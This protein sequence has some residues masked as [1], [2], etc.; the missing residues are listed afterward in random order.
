LL[1]TLLFV[2]NSEALTIAIESKK[3]LTRAVLESRILELHRKLDDAVL[4]HAFSE[5]GTLQ[6]ELDDLIAKRVELPTIQELQEL[7]QSLEVEI[8]LAAKI[9]D[10]PGA[11]LGQARLEET[12]NRL[13][14]LMSEDGEANFIGDNI[15]GVGSRA[16]LES[17]IFELSKQVKAALASKNYM[18]ASSFQQLLDERESLRSYF[19]SIAE[20]E[21][22]IIIAKQDLESSIAK[23]D[24]AQAGRVQDSVSEL[25]KILEAERLA[26]SHYAI[27]KDEIAITVIGADGTHKSIETR[28]EL[29]NE[30]RQVSLLMENA[31]ASRDFKKANEL[32]TRVDALILYRT[33]LPSVAELQQKLNELRS[34]VKA[35]VSSKSFAEADELNKQAERLEQL[36]AKEKPSY[37]PLSVVSNPGN[38]LQK[39][40][41]SGVSTSSVR[42]RK[43]NGVPVEVHSLSTAKS[44]HKLRPARPVSLD[45]STSITNSAIAMAS[46]RVNAAVIIGPEGELCGI[47]T[48]TDIVSPNVMMVFSLFFLLLLTCFCLTRRGEL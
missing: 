6:D 12:R 17:E 10:F 19:P 30:I 28:G 14:D 43:G 22:K 44:V 26:S 32:Q 42:S 34:A 35:A 38:S 4:R 29:E 40:V 13:S 27:Q 25:E 46:K 1:Q 8:A 48:D 9:R 41:T 5:C 21:Q 33:S 47:I 18:Q 39:R 3:P 31:V 2:Y 24:F 15:A 16:E 36:L 45:G 11:A 23:K 7:I 37:G 20:L